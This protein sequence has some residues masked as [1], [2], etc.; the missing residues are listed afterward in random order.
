[1][2]SKKRPIVG[3]RRLVQTGLLLVL[4]GWMVPALAADEEQSTSSELP[5]HVTYISGGSIYVDAG[6]D[7][8]LQ[9]GDVLEV[10]RDGDT[11]A[12]L[13]VHA[14]STKR[15]VAS[16]MGAPVEIFVGD[17][18]RG[19][20]LKGSPGLA[21][22]SA[23]RI[24]HLDERSVYLDSGKNRGL[25]NGERLRVVRDGVFVAVIQLTDVTEKGA[26]ATAIGNLS[27]LEPG[28]MTADPTQADLD[29]AGPDLLREK[30]R[31]SRASRRD[32]IVRGRVGVRYL[33]VK[34]DMA[35]GAGFSQPALLLRFDVNGA[36]GNRVDIAIDT[37]AR[38]TY[39]TTATGVSDQDHQTR[40][41]RLAAA[42]HDKSSR[43]VLTVGRQ[44]SSA[45]SN[46]S[47]FDGALFA[48]NRKHVSVGLFSGTQPGPIDYAYDTTIR[49]H[50]GYFQI[51]NRPE[52]LRR[53]SVTTGLIGSYQ[54]GQI[55]REFAYFQLL[56]N[57]R[58]G[59]IYLAQELD[60]NRDW[61]LVAGEDP[62]SL[63]SSYVNIGYR[64]GKGF[65]LRLGHDD[66]RNI[67]LYRDL[68]T[69]ETDFDDSF[70]TGTWVGFTQRVKKRFRFG[71]DAKQTDGENTSQSN[72]YTLIL[73]ANRITSR[74]L[75]L[76]YRGTRYENELTEGNLH[77]LNINM[78]MVRW[79]RLTLH[80]GVRE[81]ANLLDPTLDDT[82]KW[83][84]LALDFNVG[85]QWFMQVA[86]ERTDG[87]FSTSGQSYLSAT[88]RF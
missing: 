3:A 53:W 10:V 58:R 73:G 35:A 70:R 48:V 7:R 36:A 2:R 30:N 17:G 80:G 13:Q 45:A 82:V 39:K 83:Y 31:R 64:I 69:P 66:R 63:T 19:E 34:D 74:N 59:S 6:L 79:A 49:E 68:I 75:S 27:L 55:N 28:D 44:F 8:G 23:I 16:F 21:P 25:R 46:V 54:L 72:T 81:D 41:Y 57:G 15:S 24:S 5:A 40:V 76:N 38:S 86:S 29:L 14:L 37:R 61:K 4:I 65:S 84:G 9:V 52:A 32:R 33:Q 60:Y 1:M 62:Y 56:A 18:I 67:R 88:Y 42:I 71:I 43:Y 85:R 22:A 78:S 26:A 77:A 87:R 11:V 47:V 12:T 50:G 51:H 20:T